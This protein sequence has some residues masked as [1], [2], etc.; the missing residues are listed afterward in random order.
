MNR[1][2][3]NA[4]IIIATLG[5]VSIFFTIGFFKGWH[6]KKYDPIELAV[7]LRPFYL[8]IHPEGE[9]PFPTVIAFHGCGGMDLGAIEWAEYLSSRGYATILV[10]SLKPR[11]LNREQ[12]CSGKKLW[13]SERAGDVLVSLF[14][15]REMPFVDQNRLFLLGWS[16]GAWAIM[17]L[18][19]MDPP[20]TLPT[21]LNRSTE[22]P[23]GGV[24]GIVLFYPF[25]EFPAKARNTGWNYDIPVLMLLA[26]NDEGT[27]DCL[28]ISSILT[29]NN[30]PVKTNIYPNTDHAFD[31]KEEDLAGTGLQRS[32]EAIADA[33]MQVGKFMDDLL[34]F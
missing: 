19:A 5:T 27:V 12:V 1:W 23:L 6:I 8:K 29:T 20:S 3:R 10:N 22:H 18:L 31:M 16:H 14:D 21:N 28:K 24:K 2:I 32:P 30:L 34:K 26:E 17:D 11:D 9:G 13:G 15:I 25:C 7:K 33:R 4:T